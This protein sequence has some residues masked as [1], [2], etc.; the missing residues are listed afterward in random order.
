[1]TKLW[2]TSGGVNPLV[3]KY[4]VGSDY[5]IDLKLLPYDL[6]ASKAHAKML[7]ELTVLDKGE[8]TDILAGLEEIKKLH[9][10]GEFK[11]SPEQED[12]HTA[13]EQYLTKNYGEAGKKVHTGRS[14]NDQVLAA[15]RLYMKDALTLL[16]KN[17][18]LASSEFN[19]HAKKYEDI[20]MPGYTHMQ[21]AMP[22]TVGKW[23]GSYADALNDLQILVAAN[24]KFIDQNPLGSASGF[25][26]GNFTPD[27]KFTSEELGFAK[28]QENE[29]YCAASRGFFELSI[30]QNISL[31]MIICSK[32]AS[33]MLLFTT[34]EFDY[35]SLPDEFTT[36]SS[37]MPNKR[38]YD[39]FEI[40]R[41]SSSILNGYTQQVQGVVS[42]LGGGFQRDL[43]LTKE[44]FIK[45]VELANST[46]EVLTQT[47]AN[48]T[49]NKNKLESAMSQ[50]LFAT[51]EV[52]KLV[53]EGASFRD[54]YK[55][56]KGDIENRSKK[57]EA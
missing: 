46:L 7:A 12:M 14:R 29:L 45:G 44:P 28:V 56:V 57:N 13:I 21:K 41:G 8:L 17:L 35:F 39:V 3:E 47:L 50:D 30:L 4:T 27:K 49:P 43:Q 38:N 42:A 31:I 5:L 19:S 18:K 26:I 10:S 15:L 16:E 48:I 54:A 23:L 6:L 34:R 55:K 37:I 33:D 32:F 24:K 20:P 11:I 53:A 9:D 36:G 40:M 25:G 2:Q 51:E 52:Y 1:M 22:T